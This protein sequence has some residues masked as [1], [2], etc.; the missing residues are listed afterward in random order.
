MK[1]W[2]F[3]MYIGYDIVQGA[4]ERNLNLFKSSQFFYIIML[5]TRVY[6]E[7]IS[8]NGIT[9]EEWVV[10]LWNTLYNAMVY[11]KQEHKVVIWDNEWISRI[12]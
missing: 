1:Y 9:H 6:T 3:N 11:S 10:L 8:L 7:Y 12:K 2:I 4:F 5:R